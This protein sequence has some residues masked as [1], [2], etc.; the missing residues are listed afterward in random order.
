MTTWSDGKEKEK[1]P[2]GVVDVC[3]GFV[4]LERV[5]PSGLRCNL[6]S[7]ET[8]FSYF[9]ST[10]NSV[11][12]TDKKI[13]VTGVTAGAGTCD[14]SSLAHRRRRSRAAPPRPIACQQISDQTENQRHSIQ[15][16]QSHQEGQRY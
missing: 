6:T 14:V 5:F 12:Q 16:V 3:R 1:A 2:T 8:P 7:E 13:I 10:V 9:Y 11:R 4:A 15:Q